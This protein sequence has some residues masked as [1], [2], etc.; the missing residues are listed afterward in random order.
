MALGVGAA[1]AAVSGAIVAAVVSIGAICATVVWHVHRRR[2][3]VTRLRVHHSGGNVLGRMVHS[4][5]GCRRGMVAIIA[6]TLVRMRMM[7]GRR[8]GI[9]CRVARILVMVARERT[10]AVVV[11]VRERVMVVV[12]RGGGHIIIDHFRRMRGVRV[13]RHARAAATKPSTPTT[14]TNTNTNTAAHVPR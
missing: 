2:R 3:S 6:Q 8:C 10:V 13:T 9:V 12:V 11:R 1:D 4:R 5:S 7:R 14:S